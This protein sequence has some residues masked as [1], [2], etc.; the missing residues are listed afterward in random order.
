[1]NRIIL[2][3]LCALN[4]ISFGIMA[5]D[6]HCAKKGKWRVSERGLF[7]ATAIFG[8]LGGTLGMF[9]LRHKTKHWYF[10][11]FFPFMLMIQVLIIRF[12]WGKGFLR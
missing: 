8:G 9:L 4:L 2:I 3:M 5:Y 12:L 11:V 10:R 6:K 7:L 1:M